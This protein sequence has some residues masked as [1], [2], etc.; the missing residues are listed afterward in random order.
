MANPVPVTYSAAASPIVG[1]RWRSALAQF[2]AG[3]AP[4]QFAQFPSPSLAAPDSS[5]VRP[6][7]AATSTPGVEGTGTFDWAANLP[8][9]KTSRR[10]FCAGGRPASSPDAQKLI[11]YDSTEN[12]WDSL[13]NPFGT[14]GGHIYQSLTVAT[15][16]RRFFHKPLYSSPLAYSAIHEWDID[17]WE[18]A[19]SF[20]MASQNIV[21]D[22]GQWGDA[23]GLCWHPGIGAQGSLLAFGGAT[24]SK[25]AR[26]D[27]AIQAWVPVFGTQTVHFTSGHTAGIYVPHADAVICG[28]SAPD[29]QRQLVIVDSNG[30][31]R[32]S[33][34]CPT[35]WGPASSGRGMIC[36]HPTRAAAIVLSRDTDKSFW[37]YEFDADVWVE[38]ASLPTEFRYANSTAT[39][40]PE[41]G[42]IVVLTG[43]SE[44]VA[45]R[46]Y[47]YRPGF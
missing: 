24:T 20:A 28:K 8:Y 26:Y 27:W 5:G 40:I 23:I 2:A 43:Q 1:G 47:V 25:M 6:F 31:W 3:V 44:E 21:S 14:A 10:I 29:D 41:L 18:H 16:I 33:A 37:T 32:Y 34:P 42:I 46:A 12:K 7:A 36:E 13:P 9:D 38:R 19:R 39:T 35:G 11:W 45:T 30:S 22:G 17:N 4:G 15:S